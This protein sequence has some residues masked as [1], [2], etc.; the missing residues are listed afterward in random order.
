MEPQIALPDRAAVP[1]PEVTPTV[2]VWPDTAHILGIGRA[3]AYAGVRSGEI[4]SIRV[5]GRIVVP[6]AALRRLLGLPLASETEP[7]A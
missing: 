4:P 2:P 1:D 7:A 6:T 5:G 3:T